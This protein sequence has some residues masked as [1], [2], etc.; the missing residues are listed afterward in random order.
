MM[1]IQIE[2]VNTQNKGAELMLI[3]VLEEIEKRQPQSKILINPDSNFDLANVPN[4]NLDIKLRIGLGFQRLTKAFKRRLHIDLTN[5]IFG[6]H[7]CPSEVDLI[8]DASGFKY[9]D[10]WNRTNSW[11]EKKE[12]YYKKVKN[13]GISIVFL[14]QAFGPFETENGKRSARMI[15]N[16]GDLV[17]ARERISMNFINQFNTLPKNLYKSC[18]FT[19]KVGGIVPKNLE[20][21]KGRVAIIPN[22]KMITHG[23]YESDSY[24]KFLVKVIN[25]LDAKGIKSF[26]LNHEGS[27]DYK[28][29]LEIN[30]KVNE[31]CEIIT[32]LD[33]KEIKGVIG[34][35]KFTIS[36]RFH[37][38]ASSLSQ[39]I[40]CLATSWN[41]KYEMLFENFGQMD[42]LISNE[43]DFIIC[44]E[45]LDSIL[46]NRDLISKSLLEKKQVLVKE[47][48]KMWDIIFQRFK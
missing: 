14:P 29:C 9:S 37:G 12:K 6:E 40:P 25:Y 21:L 33:A 36:S 4:Y 22:Y 13:K 30:G 48:D 31:K 27:R 20:Y 43:E 39:G 10:Q 44:Q 7:Y 3:A 19:F 28:L 47:I 17:F 41:H 46:E 11:L 1:T 35:A 8:L 23:G 38:V 18:D 26:L 5:T 42:N 32:G 45:K 15:L 24:L 2:G 16:Y 34:L